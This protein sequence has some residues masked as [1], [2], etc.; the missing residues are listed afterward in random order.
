MG[1]EDYLARAR[2][3]LN[4]CGDLDCEA[5]R[6]IFRLFPELKDEEEKKI[7]T[8]IL[9][10]LEKDYAAYKNS[11]CSTKDIEKCIKWFTSTETFNVDMPA[12]DEEALEPFVITPSQI[13]LKIYEYLCRHCKENQVH[14]V[15]L[16]KLAEGIYKTIRNFISVRTTFNKY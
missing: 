12:N 8:R 9:L 1:K 3:E 13:C 6:L 15:D 14:I 7:R 5:A 10:S 16:E 2:K 11:G 4:S